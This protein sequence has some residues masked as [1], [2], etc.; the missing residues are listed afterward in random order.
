MK[1]VDT[2]RLKKGAID[3]LYLIDRNYSKKSVLKLVGDRYSLNGIE[4]NI[5]YRGV[6]KKNVVVEREKK[7]INRI[8]NCRLYIDWYN[9]FYTVANYL[10]GKAL[11]I[12]NDAFLRDSGATHGNLKNEEIID[13]T[14]DLI[15]TLFCDLNGVELFFFIDKPVSFSGKM[16]EIIKKQVSGNGLKGEI[17][18]AKS[19]DYELKKQEVGVIS[20]FDSVII[21]NSK[22][23]F[24]DLARNVLEL[25]F[26]PNFLKLK[27]LVEDTK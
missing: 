27:Q 4:R 24:F 1:E 5:L 16:A 9:E 13:R 7:L 18:V 12:S 21:D 3:Y 10:L 15:F 23:N 25:E 2:A 20:S 22:L 19:P 11:F 6:F 26:S 8:E 14:L 17:M